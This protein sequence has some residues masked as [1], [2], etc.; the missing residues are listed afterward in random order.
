MDQPS[1]PDMEANDP[2]QLI[3]RFSTNFQFDQKKSTNFQHFPNQ[4]KNPTIFHN[5]GHCLFVFLLVQSQ[6]NVC[7]EIPR[8]MLL[9]LHALERLQRTI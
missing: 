5:I 9:P 6:A 2:T 7:K 4:E 8:D 3:D 1:Q